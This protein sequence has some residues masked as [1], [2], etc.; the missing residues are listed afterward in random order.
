MV[1]T[2]L[3]GCLGGVMMLFVPLF[4]KRDTRYSLYKPMLASVKN[5]DFF[6]TKL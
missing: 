4:E 1:T 3:L 2:M 5:H 6:L